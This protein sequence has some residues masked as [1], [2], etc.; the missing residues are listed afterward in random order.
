MKRLVSKADFARLTGKSRSGITKLC[1]GKLSPALDGD[2]IDLSHEAAA[3]Y[4]AE[5]RTTSAPA[6]EVPRQRR[7]S[8]P[9]AAAKAKPAPRKSPKPRPKRAPKPVDESRDAASYPEPDEFGFAEELADLTLRQIADKLG[10]VPA[11]KDHLEAHLKREH[12]VQKR[13]A[14]E[15]T[16]GN[17]VERERVATHVFGVINGAFERLLR[18]VPRSLASRVHALVVAGGSIEE[19]EKLIRDGNSSVLE[20]TKATVLRNLRRKKRKSDSEPSAE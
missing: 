18:D 19:L 15:Q 6:P 10:T 20:A 13:L 14:N 3:S 8:S 2:R 7:P 12:A 9:R 4:I 11:Y 5:H 16:M 17:L 1:K